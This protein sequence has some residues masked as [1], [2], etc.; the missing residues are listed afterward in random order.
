MLLI[1]FLLYVKELYGYRVIVEAVAVL[2]TRYA[3]GT[4]ADTSPVNIHAW[5]YE[6]V[7][8]HDHDHLLSSRF[9]RTN[10]YSHWQRGHIVIRTL[11]FSFANTSFVPHFSQHRLISGRLYV[12]IRHSPL[13]IDATSFKVLSQTVELLLHFPGLQIAILFLAEISHAPSCL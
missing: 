3:Y 4:V 5:P 9:T 1:I 7:Q 10:Q 8:A 2:R 13:E 11:S 6:L 12:S